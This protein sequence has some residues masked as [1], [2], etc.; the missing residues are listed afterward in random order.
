MKI[1]DPIKLPQKNNIRLKP[2]F[3]TVS[4][5][6]II[7]CTQIKNFSS[8]Y[9]TTERIELRS[10]LEKSK[11]NNTIKTRRLNKLIRDNINTKKKQESIHEH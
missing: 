6:R 7:N 1:L 5:R 8:P 3:K 11:Y 9:F 10:F 2:A 4:K